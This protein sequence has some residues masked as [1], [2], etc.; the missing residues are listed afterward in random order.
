[1]GAGRWRVIRQLLAE[2]LVLAVIGGALGVLLGWR[3]LRLFIAAS[4]GNV[5]RLAEVTLDGAAL[6]FTMGISLLTGVLFGL[7][8]AW[9]FSRPDLNEALKEGTRGASAGTAAGRTRNVLVAA[10]VALSVV[11][12]AGAGLML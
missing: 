12:L 4:P 10:E 6:A 9:Q 5:P 2:S 7:A 8:P 3:G 1:M 11:L